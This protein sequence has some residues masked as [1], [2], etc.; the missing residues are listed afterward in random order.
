MT[1]RDSYRV[2]QLCCTLWLVLIGIAAIANSCDARKAHAQSK[3]VGLAYVRDST[4]GNGGEGPQA[5]P[6]ASGAA[7]RPGR[8][9]LREPVRGRH[10][11]RVDALHGGTASMPTR[12][13]D[14]KTVPLPVILEAGAALPPSDARTSLS[15]AGDATP[16]RS[17]T[18]LSAL[19]LAVAQV[20]A[21]EGALHSP[22]EVS[23]IWQVVE[24]VAVTAQKRLEWLQLHSPRALGLKPCD[25]IG[26][27][28]WTW[29]LDETGA[30]PPALAA[31]GVQPDWWELH[32]RDAWLSVLATAD[33]LASGRVRA[34][35]C[36]I[37][38]VTWG[39]ITSTRDMKW[40]TRH[41]LRRLYCAP[42]KLLNDGFWSVYAVARAR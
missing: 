27:C 30:L 29:Q 36:E 25:G 14:P 19:I 5:Q 1:P 3:S 12:E 8:S 40:A 39:S 31:R 41:G 23:L 26:N 6:L 33:S 16:A 22:Y 18:T 20:A 35:P 17:V 9:V 2:L 32:R 37:A 38:P 11:V 10:Y 7:H 15:G 24:T 13:A 4:I 42:G 21:N 34:R 28:D